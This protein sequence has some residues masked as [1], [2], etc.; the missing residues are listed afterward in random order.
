MKA[1]K[2]TGLAVLFAAWGVAALAQGATSESGLQ[3]EI[4]ASGSA[5]GN[6]YNGA[7]LAP[8]ITGTWRQIADGTNV[9]TGRNIDEIEI[10][11]DRISQGFFMAGN[12]ARVALNPVNSIPGNSGL[13]R[14]QI[15]SGSMTYTSETGETLTVELNDYM[16]LLECEFDQT[17]SFW[18]EIRA[19]GGRWANGII[20]IV[21]P[22]VGM[23][24]IQNSGGGSRRV[25]LV[26]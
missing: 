5:T 7:A 1:I 10:S 23:G 24:Y 13:Q 11:Y 19:P 9:T 2:L 16:L 26:R 25:L 4:C 22:D 14:G 6:S 15:T 3:S 20:S 8:F 18:W 17:A 21:S 12:G